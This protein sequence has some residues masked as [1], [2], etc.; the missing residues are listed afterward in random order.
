MNVETML[1]MIIDVQAMLV[2]LVAIYLGKLKT[3]V[4][5]HC[6]H[7]NIVRENTQFQYEQR[8]NRSISASNWGRQV[9]EELQSSYKGKKGMG[10]LILD[11]TKALLFAIPAH[12]ICSISGAFFM[13]QPL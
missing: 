11:H 4:N 3:L 1:Q 13:L 5:C 8:K 10:T 2:T 7:G 9:L 6:F 12:C